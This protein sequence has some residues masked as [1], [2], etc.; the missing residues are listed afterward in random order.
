M[1][2]NIDQLKKQLQNAEETLA[3]TR[4]AAKNEKHQS[5][6]HLAEKVHCIAD[7]LGWFYKLVNVPDNVQYHEK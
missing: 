1:K 6:Q 5:N 7:F 3:A 4:H 2:E